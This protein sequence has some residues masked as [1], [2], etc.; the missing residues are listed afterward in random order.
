MDPQW[1]KEATRRW[2]HGIFD[3]ANF[4]LVEEM[5]T[6]DYTFTLPRWETM[7]RVSLPE[8][9]KGYRTAIPDLHNVIHEQFVE[10]NTDGGFRDQLYVKRF[11]PSASL[12]VTKGA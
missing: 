12:W 9:V 10:G 3:N 1:M 11:R 7:D 6:E 2:I 8:V 4:T 5:T